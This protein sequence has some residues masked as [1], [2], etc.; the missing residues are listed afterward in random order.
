MNRHTANRA[1]SLRAASQI[2]TE[3]NGLARRDST[4]LNFSA[5]ST[6]LAIE[7][8]R[9]VEQA[10]AIEVIEGKVVRD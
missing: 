4:T 3:Y 2:A 6:A 5:T 9:A 8:G 7:V 10:G 1:T